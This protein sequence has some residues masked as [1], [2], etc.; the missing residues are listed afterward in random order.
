MECDR[1][2]NICINAPSKNYRVH[3]LITDDD[4]TMRSQLRKKRDFNKGKLPLNYNQIKSNLNA[5][6]VNHIFRGGEG[7]GHFG[8]PSHPE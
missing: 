3:H 1:I 5:I 4:T 6:C 2:L 8:Y 7:D